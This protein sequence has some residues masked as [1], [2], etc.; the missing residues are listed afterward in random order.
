MI[1]DVIS[2]VH[3]VDNMEFMASLPDKFFDLVIADPEYGINVTKMNMG[4]RNTVKPDKSKNWDGKIPDKTYF[5]ELFRV[6]K[7]QII[8][9]GITSVC[10]LINV[11]SSGIK[12]RQCTVGISQN[13]SM[14]GLH[15]ISQQI[16]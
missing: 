11:S 12:A 8:W 9:G 4:G 14:H 2:E 1:K 10:R 6:S 16:L 5:D 13:V 3:C 7:N 15:S